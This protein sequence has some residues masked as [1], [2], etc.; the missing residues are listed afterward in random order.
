MHDLA[1]LFSIIRGIFVI[2]LII[3]MYYG[4]KFFKKAIAWLDTH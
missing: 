2:Y 4:I 1:Y 3:F